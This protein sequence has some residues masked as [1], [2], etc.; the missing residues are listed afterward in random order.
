MQE[1]LLGIGD[2]AVIRSYS[3]FP[4]ELLDE[5]LKLDDAILRNKIPVP[6]RHK[7]TLGSAS[8]FSPMIDED[9]PAF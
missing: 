4:A 1:A 5:L 8:P 9:T 2:A 7:G 3:K 6:L